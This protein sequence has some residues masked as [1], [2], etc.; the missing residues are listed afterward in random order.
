MY[1]IKPMYMTSVQNEDCL[2][3]VRYVGAIFY[4]RWSPTYLAAAPGLLQDYMRH[5]EE[6]RGEGEDH[7]G[8]DLV[9]PFIPLMNQLAPNSKQAPFSLYD[10]LYPQWFQLKA[11]VD[12]GR[13]TILPE[14]E[15]NVESPFCPPGLALNSNQMQSLDINTWVPRCFSSHEIELPA[16]ADEHPLLHIP[17]KV[18][19]KESQT[20]CFFKGLGAGYTGSNGEIAAFH[21]AAEATSNGSLYSEARICRL[22][23]LVVDTLGPHRMQK[24]VVGMLLNYIHP[25]RR[26]ILGTLQYVAYEGSSRKNLRRWAH[27]LERQLSDLHGAGCIWGDAKPENVLVDINDNVWIIDFGR[28]YTRGWVEKDLECTQGGDLAAMRKI[29]Q[30]LEDLENCE[31]SGTSG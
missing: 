29:R 17:T 6:V 25:K 27:E 15:E 22:H 21:T 23:G 11:T 4:L 5:L 16:N 18:I 31:G 19:S 3:T 9:Q 28:G 30:W 20:E 24:R 1:P 7:N 12:E 26:G 8:L 10:Y 14:Q 2:I 13:W